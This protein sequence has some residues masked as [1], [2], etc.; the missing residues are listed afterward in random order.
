MTTSGQR[1]DFDRVF[2]LCLSIG[3][4][5]G[6]VW[7]LAYLSDVLLPF[8]IALL[9]AYLLN[10]IVDA[11]EA[12]TNSRAWAVALTLSLFSVAMAILLPL[13][14]VLFYR[15]LQGIGEVL[16]DV[17]LKNRIEQVV[18]PIQEVIND[19]AFRQ[20][21]Q[22]FKTADSAQLS[23]FV[24]GLLREAV[25]RL[26]TVTTLA[27][28]FLGSVM[29][30]LLGLTVILIIVLY[31]VFLLLDYKDLRAGWKNLLPPQYREGI[32][33]FLME[34]SS[35]MSRYF[36]GQFIVA[37]CCGVLFAIG[38]QLV[39]IN[40]AIMLGL[41]VGSLNMVPYLQSIGLIPAVLLAFLKAFDEQISIW[42]PLIGVLL[43]F[44]VVQVIQ[45]GFLV[46]KIMG[47]STGLKPWVIMLSIFIWGKLLGFLGLV[48]AIP[49]S[50]LGLA[51]YQRLILGR[52]KGTPSTPD[53]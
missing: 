8:A 41:F 26:W 49:L 32:V 21:L 52:H 12:K 34:F 48:L 45:D 46:P 9:M 25:P 5:I 51:Y 19:P 14:G 31:L 23:Q 7:L 17:R 11:F 40:M 30:A 38:F 27:A 47:K 22:E 6:V 24:I 33:D 37:M 10:P 29:N 13:I 28:S 43:V 18:V 2:R 50:C 53:D 20:K 1:Y 42:G 39:G 36:R 15:E 35:A 3:V 44:A 16:T 4:L